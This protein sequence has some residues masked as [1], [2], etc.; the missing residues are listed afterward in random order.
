MKKQINMINQGKLWQGLKEL[1]MKNKV[2]FLKRE[3]HRI[4]QWMKYSHWFC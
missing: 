1:H 4:F 3:V 2:F